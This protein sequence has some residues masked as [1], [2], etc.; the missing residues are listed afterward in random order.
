MKLHAKATHL[1]IDSN[2]C[3]SRLGFKDIGLTKQAF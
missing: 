1:Y 3:S 2:N